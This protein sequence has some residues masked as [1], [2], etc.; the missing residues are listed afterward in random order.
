MVREIDDCVAP[1]HVIE[2]AS[3]V[4]LLFAPAPVPGVTFCELSE[5]PVQNTT[6]ASVKIVVMSLL[7]MADC[8]LIDF[9][10]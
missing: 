7:L 3:N 5:H 2:G 10:D 4:A 1:E 9:I 8:Q 6:K